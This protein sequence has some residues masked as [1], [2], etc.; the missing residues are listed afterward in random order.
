MMTISANDMEELRRAGKLLENP[1]LAAKI[2]D[3]LG[4]PIE[5]GF[6]MLPSGW[7][8]SIQRATRRALE[9][10]LD[11]A[12]GT[13]GE[14]TH[15]PSSDV[16]HKIASA[17]TGGLGGAFGLAA[18]AIELPVTTTIMMRSIA[19]IAASHGENLNDI[20]ARLNCLQVF[21]FGGRSTTDDASESGY[22]AVRIAM[23][24]AVAEAIESIAKRGLVEEGAPA[25][26]RFI[27]RIASRF[28]IVVSEKAAAAAVPIIGAAGG[29]VVNTIFT[30]HFQ[31]MAHGHFAVRRL[32]RKYGTE[33]VE[34]TYRQMSMVR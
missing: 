34:Q 18:L 15:E 6:D 29:A 17:I 33:L 2:T 21:A 4:T 19:E 24:K 8:N 23:A 7:R 28:G 1:G 26:V 14:E 12:V 25:V 31:N 27:T 3:V 20:E 32:E 13:L 11:V 9:R 10:A 5:K 16:G 22:Y 30:D